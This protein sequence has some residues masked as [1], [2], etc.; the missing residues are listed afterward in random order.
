MGW[1]GIVALDATEEVE[2]RRSWR[3]ACDDEGDDMLGEADVVRI[4]VGELARRLVGEE[5]AVV[6]CPEAESGNTVAKGASGA[7]F[8][9]NTPWP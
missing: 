5:E 1:T 8:P 2:V 6:S 9:A 3:W 7:G 4:L